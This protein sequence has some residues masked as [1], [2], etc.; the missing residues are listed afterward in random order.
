MQ[1]K[2]GDQTSILVTWRSTNRYSSW[3][4]SRADSC[5]SVYITDIQR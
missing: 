5:S 2:K 4:F 3:Y 1:K